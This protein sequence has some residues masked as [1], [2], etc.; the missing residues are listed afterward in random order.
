[1]LPPM[2]PPSGEVVAWFA[3]DPP[4]A[5]G[6]KVVVSLRPSRR[7][8]TLCDPGW[9]RPSSGSCPK[10]QSTDAVEEAGVKFDVGDNAA[11]MALKLGMCVVGKGSVRRLRDGAASP[12]AAYLAKDEGFSQGLLLGLGVLRDG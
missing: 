4:N 8:G 7:A 2:S 9:P 12:Q 10:F 11:V 6:A 5:Y 3:S 1:M